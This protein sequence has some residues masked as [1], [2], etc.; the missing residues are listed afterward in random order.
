MHLGTACTTNFTQIGNKC[1]HY[2]DEQLDYDRAM[3]KCHDMASHMVEFQSEQ[4]HNEVR[5]EAESPS[6]F[7]LVLGFPHQ[8]LDHCMDE[9][10]VKTLL[11]WP[12]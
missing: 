4:E 10:K 5:S 12:H 3:K 8:F 1:L 9:H 6:V 11:D 7:L 2:S